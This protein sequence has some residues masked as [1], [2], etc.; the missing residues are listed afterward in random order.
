MTEQTGRPMFRFR[1]PWMINPAPS[2]TNPAPTTLRAPADPQTAAQ[3]T[4]TTA[5]P[6]RLPL[7]IPTPPTTASQPQPPAPPAPPPRTEPKPPS[8]SRQ[9]P[10]PQSRVPPQ[11][12][13]S[14]SQSQTT[15]PRPQAAS[16]QLPSPSR[17]APQSRAPSQPPSPSRTANTLSQPK[18]SSPRTESKPPSPSQTTTPSQQPKT[19]PRTEPSKSPSPPSRVASQPPSPSRTPSKPP[20]LPTQTVPQQPSPPSPSTNQRPIASSRVASKPPSPARLASQPAV[21][22][23]PSRGPSQEAALQAASSQ[24]SSPSKQKVPQSRTKTQASSQPPSPSKSSVSQPESSSKSSVSQQESSSNKAA[25]AEPALSQ[26]LAT[27]PQPQAQISS[28]PASQFQAESQTQTT[29]EQDK[30]QLRQVSTP[31]AVN[32][33]VPPEE[34]VKQ[35]SKSSPVP[36]DPNKHPKFEAE[37]KEKPKTESSTKED[38][39]TT[40]VDKEP[41]QKKS[42][43]FPNMATGSKEKH[44]GWS[45]TTSQAKQNPLKKQAHGDEK[46]M[47][48]ESKTSAAIPQKGTNVRSEPHP[49]P[50]VSQEERASLHKEIKDDISRFVHKLGSGHPMQPTGEPVSVITLTGENRGAFMQ[51]GAEFER[52]EGSVHIHRGYK[53]NQDDNTEVTT[54]GESSSKGR[55]SSNSASKENTES[56]AYINSNI[57]SINNSIMFSSSISERNPGVKMVF[58]PNQTEKMNGKEKSVEAHKADFNITHS[59]K[60]TYEPNI[61][62]RCLRGLFLE[63]SDSDP[64]KHGK[65]RRHGCRYNCEEK[66]KCSDNRKEGSETKSKEA[67]A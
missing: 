44:H 5:I 58:G 1:L 65:P 35:P 42:T 49:R 23:S 51:V 7:G 55:K 62:R 43:E 19:P 56:M 15:T 29:F 26:P 6:I 54:D 4:T 53:L 61:R 22:T 31:P 13:S 28:V 59:Q 16:A 24:T 25:K 37:T 27:E 57:Q 60:L 3:R 14:Q 45:S 36:I 39:P 33:L 50:S 40:A 18:P 52:K 48:R 38:K 32:A 11:P 47:A 8:P 34:P 17:T 12:P 46:D 2:I 41:E 9:T 20:P 67:A 64:D 10:P 30:T 66:K 63:P 21:R